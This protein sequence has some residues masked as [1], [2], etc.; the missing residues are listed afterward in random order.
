MAHEP[1]DPTSPSGAISRRAL[2]GVVLAVGFIAPLVGTGTAH[3]DTG[4][5]GTTQ[6]ATEDEEYEIPDGIG[7]AQWW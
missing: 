2:L 3:A 1:A 7:S 4:T 6:G 5:D